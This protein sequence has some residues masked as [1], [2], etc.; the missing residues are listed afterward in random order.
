MEFNII[1]TTILLYINY[2]SLALVRYKKNFIS[3]FSVVHKQLETGQ[4]LTKNHDINY[5]NSDVTLPFYMCIRIF[6]NLKLLVIIIFFDISNGIS[7]NFQFRLL[8]VVT[9]MYI[10]SAQ[11]F[12]SIFRLALTSEHLRHF[13]LGV[14]PKYLRF[15]THLH[16]SNV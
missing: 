12:I 15:S 14:V 10:Y 11:L 13:V 1:S 2:F 3:S 7:G 6:I 8:C 9:K 5:K 16:N 4:L